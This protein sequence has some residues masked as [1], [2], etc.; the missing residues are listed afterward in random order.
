MRQLQ[1]RAMAFFAIYMQVLVNGHGYLAIPQS[2]N[3]R[4]D[5]GPYG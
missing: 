3:L 5:G 1:L 2:R 4:S